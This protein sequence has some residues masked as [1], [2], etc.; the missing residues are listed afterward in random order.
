MRRISALA[1][2]AALVVAGLSLGCAD[3]KPSPAPVVVVDTPAPTASV[4]MPAPTGPAAAMGK[5]ANCPTLIEGGVT[6]I[7][8]VEG[9]VELTVTAKDE[10]AT[11]EIRARARHLT[12]VSKEEAPSVRHN[13]SGHG[14]GKFGRCSVIT[15][16]TAVTSE[17]V[18]GGA[19]ITVK[20][21]DAAEIDW[22]RRESRE[23]QGELEKPGGKEPGK[24]KRDH[25]QGDQDH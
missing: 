12:E 1:A 13:G 5:M 24:A 21:K 9:G 10:A 11:Q 7:K 19:K 20:P 3:K 18:E 22:V 6:A 4:A 23:R 17:D 2:L 15:R 25:R 14:G 16:N 8:D